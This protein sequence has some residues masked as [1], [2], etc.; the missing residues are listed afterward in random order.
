MFPSNTHLLFFIVIYSL[1]IYVTNAGPLVAMAGGGQ[2][3][4]TCLAAAAGG[5]LAYIT[6]ISACLM[7]LTVI[8]SV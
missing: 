3:H 7:G 4:A 2:C 1:L 5:W 6:C 8:P